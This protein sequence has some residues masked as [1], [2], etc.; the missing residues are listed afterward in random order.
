M[1]YSVVGAPALAFDLARLPGGDQVSGVL[2]AAL[3][4]TADDVERLAACHPGLPT[5]STWLRVRDIA[6]ETTENVADVLPLAGEAIDE[7]AAGETRLL[8]RLET[9]LLGDVD[10]LDRI[11]RRELLD[12]TWLRSGELAVQDPAAAEAADVLADAAFAGYLRDRLPEDARRAMAVPF[13]RAGVP[14][15]DATVPTGVPDVDEV[16]TVLA[17]ADDAVRRRWRAVVDDLRLHTGQWAPAMHQA[18]WALS[19]TDRLRLACDAQLAGVIAFRRAGFSARDAAYGVWNALSG[20]LQ[21]S[22]VGDVLPAAEADV[23]LRP[24][25]E[26]YA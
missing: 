17:G 13:L 15:R 11:I 21:A 14:T 7:A 10:A 2:R 1:P 25:R 16:L 20:V 23:L 9:G 5:R 12:W 22:A 3:T 19:L 24:W 18:T 26:V 6:I 8:R 4:A